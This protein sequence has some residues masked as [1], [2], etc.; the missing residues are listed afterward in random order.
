MQQLGDLLVLLRLQVAEGQILQL[1]LDMADT[2]AVSQWGVDIEHLAGYALALLIVG[3]FHR[4]DRAGA[5]GQF[6]QRHAHVINHGHQHLAQV[7]HLRLRAEHQGVARVHRGTDCCHA[8]HT[9]NQLGDNRTEA[10]MN[11][12]QRHL[13]FTHAAVDHSGDQGVLIEF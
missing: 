5:L 13:T 12:C 3:F 8:Q 9:F 2:Q 10:L 7:F 11:Q 6:D 4:T 1:P